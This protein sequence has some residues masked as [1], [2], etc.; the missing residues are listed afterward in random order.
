MMLF[1]IGLIVGGVAVLIYVGI[2]LAKGF[3]W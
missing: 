1:G 2:K 3:R